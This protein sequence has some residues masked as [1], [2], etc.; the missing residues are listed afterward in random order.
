MLLYSIDL[1]LGREFN[2]EYVAKLK[3][4]LDEVKEKHRHQN[5]ISTAKMAEWDEEM[6]QNKAATD[7]YLVLIKTL[8]E[9]NTLLADLILS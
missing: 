3:N 5:E 2:L 7:E 6:R 8:E 9:H 1:G 4:R